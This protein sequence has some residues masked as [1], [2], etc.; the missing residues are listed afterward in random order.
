MRW[1][2]NFFAHGMNTVRDP[3]SRIPSMKTAQLRIS[4]SIISLKTKLCLY[5]TWSQ[6]TKSS[7]CVHIISDLVAVYQT[8]YSNHFCKRRFESKALKKF[9]SESGT[10]VQSKHYF[11]KQQNHCMLE[12][13]SLKLSR[14]TDR[15]ISLFIPVNGCLIFTTSDSQREKFESP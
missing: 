10:A 15:S 8:K 11:H 14:Y 13:N 7:L 1:S 2:I 4:T 6:Q 9:L 12:N 3:Q 5:I